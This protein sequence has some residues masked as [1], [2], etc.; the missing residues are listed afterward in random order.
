[1]NRG[2]ATIYYLIAIYQE[3]VAIEQFHLIG[4]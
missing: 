1:M 2:E 3:K 4:N